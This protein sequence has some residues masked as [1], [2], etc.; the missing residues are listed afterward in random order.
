MS[1]LW[2]IKHVLHCLLSCDSQSFCINVS[3]WQVFI[4]FPGYYIKETIASRGLSFIPASWIYASV[5]AYYVSVFV[6]EIFENYKTSIDMICTSE[7][8]VSVSIDDKTHLPAILNELK[9]LGVVEVD[10]AMCIICVV[11][12]LDWRNVGFESIAAQALK[13]IP[14]RMISYGGSNHNISFLVS[15][16]DKKRALESLSKYLF[17]S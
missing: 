2:L 7:V 15:A 3:G 6:F 10:D 5:S 14:V 11:G 8:G 12:D 9:K 13:D 17:N 4:I 1:S 16:Y